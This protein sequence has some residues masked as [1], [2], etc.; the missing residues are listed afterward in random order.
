MKMDTTVA[1]LLHL[2]GWKAV[3]SV[4]YPEKRTIEIHLERDENFPCLC[5]RCGDRLRAKRGIYRSKVRHLPIFGFEVWLIFWRQKRHCPICNKAR[6]EQV[7]FLADE[8]PHLTTEYVFWA[9][10]IME[11][12]TPT[13]VAE[14]VNLDEVTAWRIEY[15]HLKKLKRDYKIPQ[16]KRIA[17]D[18]VYARKKNLYRGESRKEKF[19]TIIVDIDRKKVLW[20][21]EGRKKEA[22]DEFFKIIGPSGC[23]EIKSVATDEF[24]EF[25]QSIEEYCPKAKHVYDKFHFLRNFGDAVNDARNFLFKTAVP[26]TVARRKSAPKYKYNFIK[27]AENRTEEESQDLKDVMESNKMFC[28]L[29]LIKERVLTMFDV[30]ISVEEAKRIFN[31]VG[32]WI[33]EAG[34]PSLKK[35]YRR[36]SRIWSKIENYFTERV[37]SAISEG[38]N[39]VIKSL[40]RRAYGYKDME[41]FKL[42]IMQVAGYLKSR[43]FPN[44]KFDLLDG[45]KLI[46]I[47]EG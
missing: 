24:D 36:T 19:F 45:S 29:E 26:G 44:G 25:R 16:P 31:E 5:H 4:E 6:S 15:R 43:F 1:D 11:I 14:L 23:A 22:L 47:S 34:F 42:K 7:P 2:V 21:S 30:G 10:K 33:F 46:P 39:N 8:S 27:R 3:S 35:W 12:S 20:V 13:R 37:T 18:E 38:I 32:K 28:T 9:A 41:Y 17:V 40:K